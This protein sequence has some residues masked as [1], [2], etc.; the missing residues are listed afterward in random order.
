MTSGYLDYRHLVAWKQNSLQA[1]SCVGS[2]HQ[3]FVRLTPIISW[4]MVAQVA[5][6]GLSGCARH[7]D[8][9][10]TSSILCPSL[11][12]AAVVQW[13]PGAHTIG[14]LMGMG[15]RLLG[16]LKRRGRGMFGHPC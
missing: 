9:Q 4:D 16:P 12:Q 11:P 13:H 5:S 2:T 6:L 10:P 14:V 8:R 15:R 7:L 3:H 1:Q